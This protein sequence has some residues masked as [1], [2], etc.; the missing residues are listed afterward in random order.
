MDLAVDQ[1][2][3][4]A[5]G[6][7]KSLVDSSGS[8]GSAE[9]T[10]FTEHVTAKGQDRIQTVPSRTEDIWIADVPG[11]VHRPLDKDDDVISDLMLILKFHKCVVE[12][13]PLR[14][15]WRWVR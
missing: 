1:S 11:R 6:P 7:F 3:V 9:M 2:G 5:V 14:H 15:V 10:V 12:P 4:Q 8:V 13:F